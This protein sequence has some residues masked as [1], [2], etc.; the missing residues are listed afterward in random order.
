MIG[1]QRLG[2]EHVKRGP[3]Q[4]ARGECCQHII[5]DDGGAA[6]GVDEECARR[7]AGEERGVDD[8]GGFGG[9]R[10]Q[11]NERVRARNGGSEVGAGEAAGPGNGAAGAAPDADVEA[12]RDERGGGGAAQRAGPE[13][14]QRAFARHQFGVLQPDAGRLLLAI[15]EEVAVPG[16]H[17]RRDPFGHAEDEARID[18][19]DD[20]DV[21]RHLAAAEQMFDAGVEA[22]QQFKALQPG[23]EAGRRAADD[24]IG[25]GAV[26]GFGGDMVAGQFGAEQRRNGLGI[27]ARRHI[28]R[29]HERR[30]LGAASR[31]GKRCRLPARPVH[32]LPV[33]KALS[34]WLARRERRA[35]GWP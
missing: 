10:Q 2:R 34:C 1:G 5:I 17:L 25:A 18:H 6:A 8:P 26:G 23:D 33:S 7:E 30:T 21:R 19:A 4:L 13:Q 24:G 16:Q 35:W 22:E 9:G 31:R 28:D 14:G 15:E 27:G 3:G 32:G 11:R 12:E 29:L 20:G